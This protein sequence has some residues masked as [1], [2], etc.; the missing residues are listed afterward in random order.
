M[1]LGRFGFMYGDCLSI[2]R[3]AKLCEVDGELTTKIDL[4][5]SYRKN[6]FPDYLS[7]NW[8]SLFDCITDLSWINERDVYIKHRDIPLVGFDKD[9]FH[10]LSVLSDAMNEW[11][12]CEDHSLFVV[13]PEYC[14]ENIDNIMSRGDA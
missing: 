11:K 10:Y 4:I 13:F 8:D 2:G 3:Y 14:E 9:V 12:K 5:S 6:G 1:K 7:N